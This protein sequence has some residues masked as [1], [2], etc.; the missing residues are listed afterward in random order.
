MQVHKHVYQLAVHWEIALCKEV[1]FDWLI[2][3]IKVPGL[4]IVS[5]AVALQPIADALDPSDTC[6]CTF[7]DT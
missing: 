4:A 5:N 2:P 1:R 3:K 7:L 6:I